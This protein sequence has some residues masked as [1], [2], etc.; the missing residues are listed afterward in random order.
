[1]CRPENKIINVFIIF[2]V[3]ILELRGRLEIAAADGCVAQRHLCDAW[4]AADIARLAPRGTDQ[5]ILP[6]MAA[7]ATSPEGVFIN[8]AE[9]QW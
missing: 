2:L 3:H 6:K 7:A 5:L 9:K 8:K 4:L 1:M